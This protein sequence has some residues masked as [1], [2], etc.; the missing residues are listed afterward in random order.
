MKSE[1]VELIQT[2]TEQILKSL[3]II[4]STLESNIENIDFSNKKYFFPVLRQLSITLKEFNKAKAM[5]LSMN[6]QKVEN[7]WLSAKLHGG[8]GCLSENCAFCTAFTKK[9]N[10]NG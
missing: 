3:M 9:E 2:H 8:H 7:C 10:N 1:Q 6:D 5:I 4:C